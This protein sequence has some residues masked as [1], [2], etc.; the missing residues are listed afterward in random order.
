[1]TLISA[2][3]KTIPMGGSAFPAGISADNKNS[4]LLL[5]YIIDRDQI[6]IELCRVINHGVI[7]LLGSNGSEKE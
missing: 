1:M 3:Y 5:V 4:R 2:C 6:E 7:L